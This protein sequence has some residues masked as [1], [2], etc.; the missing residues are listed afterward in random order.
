MGH[1]DKQA[2]GA[3]EDCPHGETADILASTTRSLVAI[4][5]AAALNCHACLRRL[6]PAALNNGILAEEVT[7]AL[8]VA[9]GIRTRAGSLTDEYSSALVQH[10]TGQPTGKTPPTGFRE[11]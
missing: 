9:R 1:G 5:A 10:E 11:P 2:G 3:G 7:A 8:A 6:I 4:G